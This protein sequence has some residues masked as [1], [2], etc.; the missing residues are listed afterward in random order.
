MFHVYHLSPLTSNSYR[1]VHSTNPRRPM[2]LGEIPKKVYSTKTGSWIWHISKTFP[3]IFNPYVFLFLE[4]DQYVSKIP[5]S[6]EA[7]DS[8][9]AIFW[10]RTWVVVRKARI[11]YTSC[12][13][14][15]TNRWSSRPTTIVQDLQR[16]WSGNWHRSSTNSYNTIRLLVCCVLPLLHDCISKSPDDG[17]DS[18]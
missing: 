10:I 18:A 14:T 1:R 6:D 5:V 12:Y 17:S 8:R 3:R 13:R 4:S 9:I 2:Q 11:G 16:L 7:L 15:A